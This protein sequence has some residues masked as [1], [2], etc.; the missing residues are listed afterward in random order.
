MKFSRITVVF[1]ILFGSFFVKGQSN[2]EKQIDQIINW[3]YS[4]EDNSLEKVYDSLNYA[5][6]LVGSDYLI[7]FDGNAGAACTWK[8]LY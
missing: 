6:I 5:L 3:A 2:V 4:N 7:W 1:L 8:I